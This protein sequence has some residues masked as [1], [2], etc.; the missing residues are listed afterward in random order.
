MLLSTAL[1]LSV[2]LDGNTLPFTCRSIDNAWLIS[3]TYHHSTHQITMSLNVPPS[4]F[5]S[6]NE[7][8]EGVII[9]LAIVVASI[10]IVFIVV[11][12]AK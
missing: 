8:V 5:L 3:F 1:A 11:R 7:L 12:K 9:G 6:G 4:N 10:I 2:N